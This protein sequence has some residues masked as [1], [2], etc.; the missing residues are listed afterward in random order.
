MSASLKNALRGF[1]T[2]TVEKKLTKKLIPP[3]EFKPED[4][5]TILIISG[6]EHL[7]QV[8]LSLPAFKAIRRQFPDAKITALFE[9]KFVA[10]KNQF[11]VCDAVKPFYRRTLSWPICELIGLVKMVKTGF[12]FVIVF[13]SKGHSYFDV[14]LSHFNKPKYILGSE[15]SIPKGEVDYSPYNLL[16]PTSDKVVHPSEYYRSVLRHIGIK[17]YHSVNRL[18][19][20]TKVK[21]T[22]EDILLYYGIKPNELMIGITIS[23]EHGEKS[24]PIENYVELAR[25]FSSRI[26]AKV[27]I[28]CNPEDSDF[29]TQ[30]EA[31]LPFKPFRT[32]EYNLQDQAALMRFCSLLICTNIDYMYLAYAVGSPVIG[33]FGGLEEKFW[34]PGKDKFIAINS[35]NED[36]TTIKTK[37]VIEAAKK[38]LRAK[39]FNKE[40]SFDISDQTMDDY[41][42]FGDIVE[43]I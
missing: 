2:K 35:E 12:D 24:W 1:I 19:L 39:I 40:K 23:P 13:N 27:L 34:K 37:R 14:L 41:L 18:P 32:D 29:A 9:G 25:H 3:E 26:E 11:S 30:F 15:L 16:A 33:L 20:S 6:N 7:H 5:K 17:R 22:A 38:M 36:I 8:I 28:F 21:K 4:V 42:D 10:L 43:H 31:G